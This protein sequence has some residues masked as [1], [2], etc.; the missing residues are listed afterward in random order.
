MT[1]KRPVVLFYILT[2]ST[3]L[4]LVHIGSR[5]TTVLAQNTPP[6]REHCII[7]DPGHGG[8]DGGATSCSGKL[9]SSYNLEIASRLNDLFHLLGYSTRM[10]R[11]EDVSIYTSGSTLS[12][13]KLSDLKER[14]RICNETPGSILVSIHQNMYPDSKYHGAQVL[15]ASSEGSKQL[16]SQLQFLLT[17]TI[18]PGSRRQ[19]KQG[20]G[21][22]IMEH[23][24]RPGI[25][26]ECGFLSN[27]QEDALL[28]TTEYQQ[29]ICCVIVSAVS[30]YLSNT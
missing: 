24:S 13:K 6:N 29:Q 16:A 20:T 15:Y 12:Q 26:V 2:I 14:V 10:I 17:E 8:E 30:V 9:E 4:F 11:T 7:I 23:V 19:I 18:N 5:T 28:K 25:L 21:L 27:P 22:Y 1:S 3:V